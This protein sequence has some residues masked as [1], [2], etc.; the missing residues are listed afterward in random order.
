MSENIA[1]LGPIRTADDTN[2]FVA[3]GQILWRNP[4]VLLGIIVVLFWVVMSF[5]APVIAPKDPLA[6]DVGARLSAP[7]DNYY[8]GSD[9]LGRDILSRV[10]YGGRITLPAALAVVLVDGILGTIIGALAGYAG[11]IW[12]HD[13]NY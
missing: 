4:V 13:A 9:E 5:L 2:I 3:M 8:M 7:G 1:S 11:G 10:L 12:D 6:Q